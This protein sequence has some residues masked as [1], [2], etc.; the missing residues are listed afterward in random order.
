M[1][2]CVGRFGWLYPISGSLMALDH[3][4]PGKGDFALIDLVF[5]IFFMFWM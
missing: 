2:C 1:I 3:L 4:E 5:C